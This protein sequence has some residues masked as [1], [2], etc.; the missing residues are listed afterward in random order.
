MRP[1]AFGRNEGHTK[2]TSTAVDFPI[3]KTG[4]I[5]DGAAKG[6]SQPL[7]KEKK[8]LAT[9]HERMDSHSAKDGDELN[10]QIDSRV[11]AWFG[12]GLALGLIAVYFGATRPIAGELTRLEGQVATL[13]RNV[14]KLV[15][16]RGHVGQTNELLTALAEQGDRAEVATNALKKIAALQTQLIAQQPDTLEA[17]QALASMSEL[18]RQALSAPGDTADVLKAVESLNTLQDQIVAQYHGIVAARSTLDEIR[19]IQESARNAASQVPSARRAI[20]ALADLKAQ[21]LASGERIEKAKKVADSWTAIQQQLAGAAPEIDRAHQVA[22]A[23]SVIQQQLVSAA[24]EVA[25]AE[26]V[27]ASW[28]A[29]QQHLVA[30]APEVDRAR[31]V[32]Q[33]LAALK[34]EVLCGNDPRQIEEARTTLTELSGIRERLQRETAQV[35]TAKTSLDGLVILKDNLVS[36]TADLADAVETLETLGDLEHQLVDSVQSF[37]RVRRWLVEVVLFEP[38]VERAVTILKP[39]TDLANLRRLNPTDLRHAARSVADERAARVADKSAAANRG[40]ARDGGS[41]SVDC[42]EGD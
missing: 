23:W 24:P 15:G 5:S 37:D 41:L 36:R 2:A 20:E 33:G 22:G 21:T 12:A 42:S 40:P 13:E 32:G 31:D 34:D 27:A 35:A 9:L 8:R 11:W 7:C 28:K 30:A 4:P 18:Q 10:R 17:T 3:R 16:K 38:A 39:L 25:T 26:Q 19:R 14:S 1:N 29:I 6:G